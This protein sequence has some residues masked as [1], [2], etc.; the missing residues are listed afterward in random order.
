MER[1]FHRDDTLFTGG[2]LAAVERAGGCA[3]TGV[4]GRR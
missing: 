3:V 4:G 1:P 2:N